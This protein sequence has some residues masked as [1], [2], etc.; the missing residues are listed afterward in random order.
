MELESDTQ[1]STA[2]IVS[3]HARCHAKDARHG[4][5]EARRGETMTRR[6]HGPIANAIP[7]PPRIYSQLDYKTCQ[8]WLSSHFPDDG[9]LCE[10]KS[11][12]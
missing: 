2:Q 6:E 9:L 12:E 5:K 10:A 8:R 1:P 4:T 11:S 3:G 7:S